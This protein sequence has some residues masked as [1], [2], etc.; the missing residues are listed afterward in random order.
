MKF[1]SELKLEFVGKKVKDMYGTYIGK[2][3]GIVTDVD[4]SIESV[5]VD[6]GSTGIKNLPY[7]QLLVQG[8]YVIFIPRW[9][10]DA[11]KLLREKSMALKRIKALQG[12]VAENDNMKDDAEFAYLK[13]EKRL[14]KLSQTTK[15]IAEILHQR[16]S[17]LEIESKRIKS[18]LF[19]AKLQYKS[20]E[21]TEEIYQQINL[22]T[23]E[24][25]DHINLER[26]EIKNIINKLSQQTLE[27]TV[28]AATAISSSTSSSTLSSDDAHESSISIQ[29]DQY[30]ETILESNQIPSNSSQELE[31]D[32]N[33]NNQE[34]E[35]KKEIEDS[36]P[37]ISASTSTSS[38]DAD[39]DNDNIVSSSSATANTTTIDES[40]HGEVNPAFSSSSSST[41][42]V[43][44]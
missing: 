33:N 11:Q 17:E 7:E 37:M 6:C 27:N 34:I 4:G 13:Y 9:R 1:M 28:T 14:D 31:S 30:N 3:I 8:D 42:A 43:S 36:I 22:N 2:V 23:N 15:E 29:Q 35:V 44:Q 12:I 25:L 24:L 21:I 32:N 10:L 18:V 26:T 20:N 41:T 39:T 19:D 38:V 40:A 5:S 16:L